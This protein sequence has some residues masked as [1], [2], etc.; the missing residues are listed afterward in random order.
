VTAAGR[1]P[2]GARGRLGTCGFLLA[3]FVDVA[4]RRLERCGPGYG[5]TTGALD[6]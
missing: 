5:V 2:Q 6:P 4:V 3:A 1:G